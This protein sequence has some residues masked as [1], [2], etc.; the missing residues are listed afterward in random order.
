MLTRVVAYARGPRERND[1]AR[2]KKRALVRANTLSVNNN[3]WLMIQIIQL[4]LFT[5][6]LIIKIDV[7]ALL[8]NL[9]QTR[10]GYFCHIE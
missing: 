3:V 9:D 10:L 6:V 1:Q 5:I 4:T 8:S 2:A 7:E